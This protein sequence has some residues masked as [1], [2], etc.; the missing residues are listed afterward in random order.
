M[1]PYLC[2]CVSVSLVLVLVVA[3]VD[4]EHSSASETQNKQVE[5]RRNLPGEEPPGCVLHLGSASMSG[6]TMVGGVRGGVWAAAAIL[7]M[8]AS[9]FLLTNLVSS[10]ISCFQI[11]FVSS[12]LQNLKLHQ[13]RDDRKTKGWFVPAPPLTWSPV[14]QIASIHRLPLKL[15]AMETGI[16]PSASEEKGG[17]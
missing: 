12:N 8:R 6:R 1:C 13:K 9:H 15:I 11:S 7:A 2:E 5:E 17:W 16:L 3:V 14:T 10:E 4:V